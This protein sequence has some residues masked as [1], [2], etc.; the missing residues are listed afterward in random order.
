MRGGNSGVLR[1]TGLPPITYGSRMRGRASVSF[2]CLSAE[3]SGPAPSE[4][5]EDPAASE[6]RRVAHCAPCIPVARISATASKLDSGEFD[7]SASQPFVHRSAR[8]RH[9]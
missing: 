7:E 6:A 8:V 9:R 1:F 4:A 5:R 3:P 2:V